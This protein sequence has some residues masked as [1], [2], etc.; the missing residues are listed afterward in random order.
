MFEIWYMH[1]NDSQQTRLE[2][3][4]LDRAQYLWDALHESGYMLLSARP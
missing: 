2:I 4:G 3:R 1:E